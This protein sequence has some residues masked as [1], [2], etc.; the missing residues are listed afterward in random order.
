MAHGCPNLGTRDHVASPASFC[1]ATFNFLQLVSM[2]TPI[3]NDGAARGRRGTNVGRSWQA[4]NKLAA[5]IHFRTLSIRSI[6]TLYHHN[7]PHDRVTR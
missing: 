4:Q 7:C 3:P 6:C 5:A 1:K 2:K